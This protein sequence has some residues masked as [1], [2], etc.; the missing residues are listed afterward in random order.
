MRNLRSAFGEAG[1]VLAITQTPIWLGIVYVTLADE[2]PSMLGAYSYL[3]E[4]LSAGDVLSFTAGILGSSTAYAIMKIGSFSVKPILMLA[5]ILAPVVVLLFA[6]P[7]FVQDL[8]GQLKD[9]GF[10]TGYVWGILVVSAILWI[11]ALYQSRAFF[12]VHLSGS[13]SSDDIIAD[14]EGGKNA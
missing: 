10:T 4:R 9:T 13:K 12:D 2:N 14:I 11:N 7:V 8:N 1:L 5:L 3:S 6:M